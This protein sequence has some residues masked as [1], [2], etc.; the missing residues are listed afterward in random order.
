M[1]E[2]IAKSKGNHMIVDQFMSARS[3]LIKLVNL[4]KVPLKVRAGKLADLQEQLSH[5]RKRVI[6]VY[7]TF[8]ALHKTKYRAMTAVCVA[9]CILDRRYL[10]AVVGTSASGFTMSQCSILVSSW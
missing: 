3:E 9:S 6:E 4:G 8:E 5:A 10:Q 7:R 1:V 2:M